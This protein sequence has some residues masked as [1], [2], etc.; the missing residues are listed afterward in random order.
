[1]YSAH[2]TTMSMLYASLNFTSWECQRE[3][4]MK[5][6]YSGGVCINNFPGF[7]SSLIFEVWQ[8][9]SNSHYIKTKV[10]GTYLQICGNSNLSCDYTEFKSRMNKYKVKNYDVEC[11]RLVELP[12]TIINKIANVTPT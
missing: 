2:D 11:G 12:H 1:M 7:A 3:I 5:G 10:N 8:T 4:F 9:Q 6:S